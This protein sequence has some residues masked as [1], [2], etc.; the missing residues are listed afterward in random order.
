MLSWPGTQ[1][2]K[3]PPEVVWAYGGYFTVILALAYIPTYLHLQSVGKNLR[4][5]TFPLLTPAHKSFKDRQERREEV[6][7][8]LELQTGP[9]GN[10]K[11]NVAILAP[12]ASSL[13]SV[14]LGG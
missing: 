1:Q 14:L 12:L 10:M 13:V 2:V 7:E 4:D 11:T 3:F 5:D 9:L 8:L 6:D